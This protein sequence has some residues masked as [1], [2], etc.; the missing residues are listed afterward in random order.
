MKKEIVTKNVYDLAQE[1]LRMIFNEFDN[2]YIS[3][4][5]GKDSGVLLNLCI[6]YIRRN[7][8]NIRLGVF[9]MDYVMN[10]N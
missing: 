1:R 10:S 3:F 4:S 5:G 6:D 8:L 9:H 2:V 7:N